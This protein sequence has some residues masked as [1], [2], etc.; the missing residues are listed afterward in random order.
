M[1]TA[2]TFGERLEVTSGISEGD[3]IASEGA[4]LLKSEALRTKMGAG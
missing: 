1:E 3:W 2:R 4:F